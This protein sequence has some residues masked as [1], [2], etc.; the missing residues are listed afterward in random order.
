MN[1][2]YGA[3]QHHQIH[4]PNNYYNS[5]FK[6]L[7]LLMS[8]ATEWEGLNKRHPGCVT[9]RHTPQP[10]QQDEELFTALCVWSGAPQLAFPFSWS[11]LLDLCLTWLT[12]WVWVSPLTQLFFFFFLSSASLPRLPMLEWLAALLMLDILSDECCRLIRRSVNDR[13]RDELNRYD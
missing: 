10:K 4:L 6:I 9:C 8:A 3:E 5:R 1:N 7:R 13:K 2:S 12:V 11:S